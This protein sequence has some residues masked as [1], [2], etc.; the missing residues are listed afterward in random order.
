M[1]DRYLEAGGNFV[2][3]ANV[4]AGGASEEI[5][6]RVFAER[7]G[8]RDDTVL[9]TKVRM[10]TGDAINDAGAS[11]RNIR[12]SV[13]RSL[14]RLQTEWI[15]LYQIHAYDPRT[16]LDETLSTL[17]D[18][19]REGKVRYI[20]ASNYAGWQLAKALGL[21]ALHGWERFVALQQQYSLLAREIEREQLPLCRE[22][23]VGVLVFS[24]LAGGL[25]TGKYR[26]SPEAPEGTRGAGPDTGVDDG[27][28]PPRCGRPH[29]HRRRDRQGR[30]RRREDSCA[31]RAQLGARR[32]TA[33][34]R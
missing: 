7:P 2:D 29:R 33:S 25:L 5:L 11:R 27:A 34:R 16:P 20:G 26:A 31:G 32:A 22:E 30:G 15:D 6:G 23:G 18:L 13:E 17:D 1:L 9:A 12:A 14:R 21:S 3:T 4:Y 10:P 24:P 28:R 19:V 8:L